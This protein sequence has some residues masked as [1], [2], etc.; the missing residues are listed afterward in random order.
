MHYITRLSILMIFSLILS[1]SAFGQRKNFARAGDEA[2]EDRKYVVAIERYKKAQGKI[3]NN[4]AEKDRVA[5]RLAEC[6]R[7]TG[8]PK[9]AKAQYKRLHKTG[10][11]KK[12]PILLLHYANIMKNEGFPEEALEY[13]NLY[14]EAVPDDPRGLAGV[15][16]R[17]H[18]HRFLDPPGDHRPAKRRVDKDLA[19]RGQPASVDGEFPAVNPTFLLPT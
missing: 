2:F 17:Q 6:Y 1:A 18:D 5:F 7:L 4:K 19:A 11:A 14:A 3:K 16:P 12:E 8:N 9:A 15:E 10:Y 13:Y